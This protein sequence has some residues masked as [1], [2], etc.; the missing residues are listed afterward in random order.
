MMHLPP[1]DLRRL[2][3]SVIIQAVRD[4]TSRAHRTTRDRKEL[5]VA[6]HRARLWLRGQTRD[7]HHVCM[8]AGI[9][10]EVVRE[11]WQHKSKEELHDVD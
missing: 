1:D 2:W 5:R 3:Q 6:R 11:W 10:P 7:F 8:L 9:E 4:A